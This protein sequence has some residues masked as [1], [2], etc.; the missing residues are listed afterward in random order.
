MSNP[1]TPPKPNGG[2]EIAGIPTRYWLIGGGAAAVAFLYMHHKNSLAAAQTTDTGTSDP[3]AVDSTGFDAFSG[4]GSA[5]PADNSGA[6]T[7]GPVGVPQSINPVTGDML[8]P[9]TTA[10]WITEAEAALLSMGYDPNLVSG[11]LSAFASGAPLTQQQQGAIA[12]AGGAVGS[13]PGTV[14]TATP[15]PGTTTEHKIAIRPVVTAVKIPGT[16]RAK[17]AW[18]PV[19]YAT[20]YHV[21]RDGAQVAVILA[22][23]L[24]MTSNALTKGTHTFWIDAVNSVSH[25]GALNRAYVTI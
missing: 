9:Q 17:V 18:T 1:P 7:I 8:V 24:T 10:A 20:A 21:W 6:S 16:N 14:T 4:S 15:V 19:P 5:L 3:N 22:P 12:S 2:K 23:T 13:V 25:L 11:A